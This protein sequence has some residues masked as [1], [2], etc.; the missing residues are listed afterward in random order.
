MRVEIQK[1]ADKFTTYQQNPLNTSII[2]FQ[3]ENFI[4]NNI[5]LA[6]PSQLERLHSTRK[7]YKIYYIFINHLSYFKYKIIH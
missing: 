6:Y 2:R 5:H 1:L 3:N 7:L 4:D